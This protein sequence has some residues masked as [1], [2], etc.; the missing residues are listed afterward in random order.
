MNTVFFEAQVTDEER[1]NGLYAGSS[2]PMRRRRARRAHRVT[3]GR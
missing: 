2:S 3:P 1:R